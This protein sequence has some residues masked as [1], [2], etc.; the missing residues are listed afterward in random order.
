MLLAGMVSSAVM[1]GSSLISDHPI[2]PAAAER[3]A[4]LGVTAAAAS[5]SKPTHRAVRGAAL[6]DVDC[7]SGSH[8][9]CMGRFQRSGFRT[10]GPL[11][12]L[13]FQRVCLSWSEPK[14]GAPATGRSAKG[15]A[16]SIW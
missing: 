11:N 3:K 1:M 4:G 5:Y 9:T 2:F 16:G 6:L 8:A 13:D 14:S 12:A 7:R 15:R 10:L